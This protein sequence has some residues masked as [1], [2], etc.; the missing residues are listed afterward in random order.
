MTRARIGR[1]LFAVATAAALS[2]PALAEIDLARADISRLPNG[3]T[4]ML[5]EDHGFPVVSVQALYKSGSADETAGKTGLAHF[6]EHL[7]FRGSRNFPRGAATEAIYNAGGEWHGYTWLD[8]TT[9]FATVPKDDLDLLLRIEADRM[10]NV[11][12]DPA[13]IEAEKGAVIAEMHGYEN[14]P[15]SVL[16]DAVTATAIQAHPYRNNT[17]GY[18]TDVAALNAADARAYYAAHY[19]PANAVLAVVG[20]FQFDSVKRLVAKRFAGVAARRVAD[21]VQ[22]IEPVQRGER[23]TLLRGAVDRQHFLVAYPAPAASSPDLPAFL[24]LQQLLGG[25][26]GLNFRENDWGTAAVDG[27]LLFGLTD[28][29]TTWF[30]P[31]RD[32]Y[33]FTIGGSIDAAANQGTLEAEL[34]RRITAF[35]PTQLD[36][37]KAAVLGELVADIQTTEDAAHQLAFFEGIGAF[38]MLLGLRE[39]VAAVTPGDLSRVAATYLDPRERTVGWMV[40]GEVAATPP[41]GGDARSAA[42]RTGLPAPIVALPPAELFTL[43]SGLPVAFQESRSTDTVA[44]ELIVSAPLGGDDGSSDMPGLGLISRSG[45]AGNLPKLIAGVHDEFAKALL[46]DRRVAQPPSDDPETR[47]QQLAA[48]TMH[49]APSRG[50]RP[51]LIAISGAADRASVERALESQFAA[52]RPAAPGRA[53]T[54]PRTRPALE[55]RRVTI[56]KPLSQGALGY[57]V[58]APPPGTREGIVWRLLRYIL[59]HDY[60]GRLGRSAITDKG[61]LYY[62]S[63]AY[64]TD[65]THA[66][67]KIWGGVDPGKADAFEQELR[68]QLATLA[69][70]PPTGAEV[71]AAKRNLL[72]RDISAAQS[73]SEIAHKL[74]RQVIETGRLRSHAELEQLVNSITPADVSKAVPA[75]TAGTILRVDVKH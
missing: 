62:I 1:F 64:P 75:F 41:G 12:I 68:N 40:P 49:L 4:V 21:A 46:S 45:A 74:A 48:E 55:I 23:R 35:Q 56:D 18:E 19:A 66:W 34:D 72:G 71:E 47:L 57:I 2:S 7:A 8:Q 54:T 44:I 59:V 26:S 37:A 14:D 61:L 70:H 30:I 50:L 32:R 28:D 58:P 33:L 16:L 29:L 13:A 36:A 17:I 39:R 67:I 73:N 38:D 10:A 5:L 27:S 20:D 69:T 6:L 43:S 22:S 51:L 24:V 65:G 15:S 31:T 25:G 11:E 42:D 9:Y 3:L 63:S 60:S 52:L 53:G